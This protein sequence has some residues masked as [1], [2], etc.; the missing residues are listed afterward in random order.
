MANT[1]NNQALAEL[2]HRC[3]I[4]NESA[5]IGS[6]QEIL[7]ALRQHLK[8]D[9]AFISEFREG[10]R[11]FLNVNSASSEAP[12]KVGDSDPIEESYCHRIVEGRLPELILDA[13]SIPE[14][15]SLPAT[16]ALPVGAHLGVPLRFSVSPLE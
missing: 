16:S 2:L 9:I 13:S 4:A 10:R 3:E 5:A 8:M 14:A 1:H 12:I 6:I 15:N 11:V 7:N